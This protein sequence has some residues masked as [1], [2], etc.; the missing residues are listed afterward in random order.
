MET[1]HPD[2]RWYAGTRYRIHGSGKPLV[3]IHGVGLTLEHWLR[4]VPLLSRRRTLIIYDAAGH[5]QSERPNG[6]LNMGAFVDQLKGM[7]DHLGLEQFDLLGYSMGALIAEGFVLRHPGR[8]ARLILLSGVYDRTDQER[9][10]VLERV[11]QSRKDGY[12]AY[13]ASL[14]AAMDRYLTPAFRAAHPEVGDELIGYLKNNNVEDFADAYEFFG[15]ADAELAR[16]VHRI[17]C[18]TLVITGEDDQRST[19]LMS[20]MLA[21]RIPN[22]EVE[23][24]LGQRHMPTLEA[25]QQLADSVQRFLDA[26]KVLADRTLITS[27]SQW[28]REYKYSRA[29]SVGEQVYV[30]GTTGFDYR[31]MSVSNDVGKQ[32]WQALH[33][34][35]MAL[36]KAG[37]DL[38]EVVRVTYYIT[39]AKNWQSV[40]EV[41][42]DVFGETAPTS[43]VVVCGLIDERMK[44]E[45]EATAVRR[46]K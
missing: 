30:S 7:V 42:R 3:L 28:E 38:R 44:V 37:S 13:V 10:T 24:M 41:H 35:G 22:A 11:A 36:S 40:L 34:V 9:A 17:V 1:K 2:D 27:G 21:A 33:N 46:S 16:D 29:L 31:T 23:I 15:T 19:A 14:G 26:G 25:P 8:V 18:P 20:R 6:P 43:S 5:G 4:L 32:T 39:E 12:D 45:V